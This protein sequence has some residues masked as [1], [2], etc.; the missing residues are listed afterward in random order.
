MNVL[1]LF[2]G[3]SCGQYA[4]NKAGIHVDK[5]LASEIDNNAIKIT[6][7]NFPRTGH[8]GDITK[9]KRH[10]TG[11]LKTGTG[12]DQPFDT[13][14]SERCGYFQMPH[15][16]LL[17][18]G[19]PC[20]GLRPGREGLKD[21]NSILFFEYVRILGLLKQSNNELLFKFENVGYINEEDKHTISNLL[22]T[23]PIRIN[24]SL[25]SAQNRDRYYWTNIPNV[26][27]PENNNILLNNIIP[28]AKGAALRNQVTK[29]GT[30][31][32]LNIRK[33]E[34]S[35]CIVASFTKKLNGCVIDGK[36]RPFTVNE[37]EVIQG[38]PID[39]TKLDNLS[40]LQRI[41]HIGLGWSIPVAT[42][43]FKNI[44]SS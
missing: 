12:I 30:F 21:K 26:V 19:S 9:I 33:D 6:S 24:A 44:P 16:D 14:Y 7:K 4:L 41:K 5:Y 43:I 39:Y 38:L 23:S 13:W 27:V 40:D 2:D 20:N 18:G 34:K 28:N 8:L 29:N 31:P 36:Y 11:F 15:I 25:V 1:S 32:F 3:I 10:A 35:N 42:H 17:I 22:G 37:C